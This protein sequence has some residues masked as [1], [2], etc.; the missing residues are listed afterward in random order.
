M[1]CLVFKLTLSTKEINKNI[2][3]I[4]IILNNFKKLDFSKNNSKGILLKKSIANH[5]FK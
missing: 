4:R 2:L 1:T 3:L 5:P